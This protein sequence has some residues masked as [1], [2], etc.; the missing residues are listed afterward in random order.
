M[1]SQNTRRFL[2]AVG[3]LGLAMALSI[4]LTAGVRAQG[5][6]SIIFIGN[7]FTFA[8]GSVVLPDLHPIDLDVSHPIFHAF[9]DIPSFDIVRQYY[10]QG[11]PIFRGIFEDNDPKKRLLVMINFNTDIS[12][13][14]EYSA[15]GF[16]PMEESNEAY[17][18]GVNYLFYALTH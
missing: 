9:F 14:W 2:I 15:L 4:G 12:N 3:L 7:S 6:P 5:P 13:F 10:D 17:E 1:L 11:P 16:M 18:L 8:A